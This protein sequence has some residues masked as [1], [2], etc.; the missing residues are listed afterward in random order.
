MVLGGA[1]PGPSRADRTVASQAARCLRTGQY[2]LQWAPD[3]PRGHGSP[4]FLF[5]G[6]AAY[7]PAALLQ[8]AGASPELSQRATQ[9]AGLLLTGFA[10]FLLGRQLWG[11]SAGWT[12]ALAAVHLP[13]RLAPALGSPEL[14]SSVALA[15]PLLA[16]WGAARFVERRDA[17]SWVVAA[18]GLVALRITDATA[19]LV[20]GPTLLGLGFLLGA[21]RSAAGARW[22]LAAAVPAALG[23]TAFHWLP[24]WWEAA[25]LKPSTVESIAELATGWRG[26]AGVLLLG[27]LALT[28]AL[29]ARR[30]PL[31]LP[32]RG[33]WVGA[34]VLCAAT[35]P[36]LLGAP[37]AGGLPGIGSISGGLVDGPYD[38]LL[39]LCL[40][41]PVALAILPRLLPGRAG[42]AAPWVLAAA[43]AVALPVWP[44]PQQ[45][46][47]PLRPTIPR[48]VQRLP[49]R[50][51]G[52]RFRA[53]EGCRLQQVRAGSDRH[54]VDVRCE[55]DALL[56]P[57][58]LYFPGWTAEV[59][60]RAVELIIDPVHGTLAVPLPRGTHRVKLEF[61]KTS[62]RTA[63]LLVTL[64]SL[65][66]VA[67]VTAGTG[68]QRPRG[69][70]PAWPPGTNR[71]EEGGLASAGDGHLPQS[72]P[73][74]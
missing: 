7:Y 63:G 18:G 73:S 26:P 6:P 61:E 68:G 34:A 12:A 62:A 27:A 41:L 23:A 56:R 25:E 53:P 45:Q 13:S 30:W 44:A 60:K 33:L 55:R 22:R 46:P 54:F 38:P 51:D 19:F 66:A 74:A 21:S 39:P 17:A 24:A 2:L 28:V 69:T 1:G 49:P 11:P 15:W 65:L 35:V 58:L 71:H 42:A 20:L 9:A 72:G 37:G 47:R 40:L 52:D 8:M 50:R 4:L 59:D 16:L 31:D 36:P 67:A 57:H 32:G 64:V 29:G 3:H 43:L 5:R 10:A 48:W 14:A 70:K